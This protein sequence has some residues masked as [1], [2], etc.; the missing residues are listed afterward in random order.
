MFCSKKKNLKVKTLGHEL[1]FIFQFT[2]VILSVFACFAGREGAASFRSGW[3]TLG[4]F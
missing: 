4:C 3:I 2:C 1:F